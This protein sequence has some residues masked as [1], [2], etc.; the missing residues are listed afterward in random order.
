MT[1]C[2]PRRITIVLYLILLTILTTSLWAGDTLKHMM[3]FN[4]VYKNFPPWPPYAAGM[5]GSATF[6]LRIDT[7]GKVGDVRFI[8]SAG[9]VI[10]TAFAV[11]LR[12]IK[13]RPRRI[14]GSPVDTWVRQTLIIRNDYGGKGLDNYEHAFSNYT[15]SLENDTTN[16]AA[17][18]WGR[19]RI[20][21]LYGDVQAARTDF[22][23][24]R[25]LGESRPWYEDYQLGLVR[26]W[27]PADTV[28]LDSLLYRA[29]LYGLYGLA[30]RARTLYLG[31]SRMKPDAIAPKRGLM[32]LYG[33]RRDY[34]GAASIATVL[35]QRS[36]L[37]VYDVKEACWWLYSAGRYREA[38]A[39]G[40]RGMALA[41]DSASRSYTSINYAI[42]LLAHGQLSAA[43]ALYKKLIGAEG[44]EAVG[45]LKRHIRLGRPNSAFA[46]EVLEDIYQLHRD[47]IP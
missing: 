13:G 9:D 43:R 22:E 30:E 17:R 33:N 1:I 11:A 23:T 47:E 4:H 35:L 24:A 8:N 15:R 46:R 29:Y 20:H 3:D 12:R 32:L 16:S 31:L 21:Y 40:E 5:E 18:F 26:P 27:L 45:D 19:G 44:V 7:N 28:A 2:R 34:E 38:V 14:D 37:P 41:T 42:S 10:D 25:T 36:D 39:A 6:D